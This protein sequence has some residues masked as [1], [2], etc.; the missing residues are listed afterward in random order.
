MNTIKFFLKYITMEFGM[1]KCAHV[2][3]KAGKLVRVCEMELLSG[4]VIP[5]VESG[6]GH[7]YLGIF[8]ANVIT[9][10][11]MKDK[12]RRK[13]YKRVRELPSSKL[14]GGNTIGA[15]N[16]QVLSLVRYSAG[17][18]KWKKIK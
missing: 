10:T 16:S 5:E 4:E 2:T 9:H 18:L 8:E 3:M 7:K 6:K 17:M 12:I 11:E 14:N 1:R 15:I 13:H